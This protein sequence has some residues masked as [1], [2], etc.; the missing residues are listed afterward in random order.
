MIKYKNCRICNSNN[1]ETVIKFEKTPIGDA[2]KKVKKKFTTFYPLNIFF[3]KKCRSIQLKETISEKKIYNN[4]F[5]E[6]SVTSGLKEHYKKFSEQ[7]TKKYFKENKKYKILDIGSNDGSFLFPFSKKKFFCL[8]IEPTK[9]IARKANSRKIH[10]LNIFFNKKNSVKIKK[11]YGDFDL[12]SLNFILANVDYIHNFLDGVDN[13]IKRDGILI[14]ETSHIL[15]VSQKFLFD[16]FF[17]EHIFYFSLRT[18]KKIFFDRGYKFLNIE[19]TTSKG[20]SLRLTLVKNYKFNQTKYTNDKLNE[21]IK[22]E[23]DNGIFDIKTYKNFNKY[24]K[25]LKKKLNE[26]LKKIVKKQI[27]GFGASIATT[28]IIH[29][30]KLEKKINYLLDDNKLLN[31]YFTP[32]SKIKI[33]NTDKFFKNNGKYKYILILAIR[34]KNIIINRHFKNFRNKTIISIH[35]KIK[36]EKVKKKFNSNFGRLV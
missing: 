33:I 24:M 27:I 32:D 12:I 15:K 36:F 5:Y 17:H 7:L 29:Y 21:I 13:L 22:K 31:N 18:L 20:G 4:F 19:E 34:Y 28:T 1:I 2:W 25:E 14:I 9:H 6:I 8:G 16:T 3:C 11:K 10:T 26:K 35:P 23:K 30:F